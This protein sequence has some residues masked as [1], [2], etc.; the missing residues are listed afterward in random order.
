MKKVQTNETINRPKYT[1]TAGNIEW[2]LSVSTPCHYKCKLP[3]QFYMHYKYM[4]EKDRKGQCGCGEMYPV[5]KND[6]P[7]LVNNRF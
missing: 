1:S 2:S 4:A 7:E 6:H 3:L 5:K